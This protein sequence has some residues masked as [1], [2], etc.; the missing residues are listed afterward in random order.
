MSLEDDDRLAIALRTDLRPI[1]TTDL[2]WPRSDLPTGNRQVLYAIPV[3]IGHT[4]EAIAL[5][6]GHTEG[7]DLD[8]DERQSLRDL[9]QAA[10]VGYDRVHSKELRERLERA[11]AENASLHSVEQKLTELLNRHLS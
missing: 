6:G 3:V 11:E 10:A 7:E 8:P 4:V 1:V 9:A 5:Y 2:G